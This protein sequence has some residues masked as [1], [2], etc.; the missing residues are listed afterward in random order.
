MMACAT[1][2]ICS[3]A[4]CI[5]LAEQAHVLTGLLPAILPQSRWRR[6]QH[7]RTRLQNP[8]SL[9]VPPNAPVCEPYVMQTVNT[10]ANA[11]MT[12]CDVKAIAAVY[13]NGRIIRLGP[14]LFV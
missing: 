3:V 4:S 10:Y 9:F 5:E 8:T 7:H 14:I 6:D 2:A 11:V 13:Q 1:F 12:S